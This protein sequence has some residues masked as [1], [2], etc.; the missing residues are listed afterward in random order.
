V[1]VVEQNSPAK[2]LDD[3]SNT[4]LA[5][6]QEGSAT[7]YYFPVYNLYGQTFTE[8]RFASTPKQV[9]AW[10]GD[11]TVAGGALSVADLERY[12]GE[13]GRSKFRV[14]FRDNHDVP[15][16]AVL[17]GPQVDRDR[18]DKIRAALASAPAPVAAAAGYITNAE[19]PDYSYLIKVVKQ[20]RPIAKRINEK[21]APLYE[22]K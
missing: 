22:Q 9:L 12:R 14:L 7:G 11:G 16:G 18:Q 1:I 15:S 10:L 5:L 3:L 13:L 19:P 8:I 2:T 21:P 4:T 17:V 6:G 20:V